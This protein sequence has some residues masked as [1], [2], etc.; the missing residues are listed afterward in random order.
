M[1]LEDVSA[2]A[3]Q[4]IARGRGARKYVRS[5]RASYVHAATII[6]G[7]ARGMFDRTLVRILRHR[8]KVSNPKGRRIGTNLIY[9]LIYNLDL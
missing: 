9:N 6:E 8:I 5:L 4:R 7:G 2:T 3:I 1:T